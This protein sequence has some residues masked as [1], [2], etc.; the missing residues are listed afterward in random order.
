M[1]RSDELSSIVEEWKRKSSEMTKIS[2]DVLINVFDKGFD[3][4]SVVLTHPYEEAKV[5][6]VDLQDSHKDLQENDD[7]KPDEIRKLLYGFVQSVHFTLNQLI[8]EKNELKMTIE[9]WNRAEEVNYSPM[10]LPLMEGQSMMEDNTFTHNEEPL[11]EEMDFNPMEL[12]ADADVKMEE[13]DDESEPA[14]NNIV[15]RIVK[16]KGVQK[17]SWRSMV[18]NG[19]KNTLKCPECQFTH[20]S[21]AT[22]TAH[23]RETHGKTPVEAQIVFRCDCGAESQSRNNA[24][25]CPIARFSIAHTDCPPIRRAQKALTAQPKELKKLREI[26]EEPRE[27]VPIFNKTKAGR[28]CTQCHKRPA[29][30]CGYV[31]HINAKHGMSLNKAG[32]KH[33]LCICG[34]KATSN[35]SF[36]KIH[37]DECGGK[38][39]TVVRLRS[40]KE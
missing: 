15:K 39:F 10:E 33:L 5:A 14:V 19:R 32:I 29:T 6:L 9:N 34:L 12:I 21:L 17:K 27:P 31:K 13:P 11:G 35:S 16:T 36:K 30:A 20:S 24:C 7:I 2:D 38:D 26:K 22:F 25:K 23:L 3:A 37:T 4:M 28:K 18:S 1:T 40:K 8:E